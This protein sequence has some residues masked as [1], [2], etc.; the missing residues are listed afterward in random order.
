MTWDSVSSTRTNFYDETNGLCALLRY[1][2]LDKFI[3]DPYG[4]PTC[5]VFARQEDRL[6]ETYSFLEQELG[7]MFPCPRTRPWV[8]YHGV[9]DDFTLSKIHQR[10]KHPGNEP[11][12]LYLATD[13]LLMGVDKWL[14]IV[15][16]VND[17][18]FN[19]KLAPR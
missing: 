4:I 17:W 1:I 16:Q 13:K 6:G 12:K 2:F 18:I 5:I 8:Q 9:T 10:I 15:T 11:I 7:E 14:F 3:K 19:F